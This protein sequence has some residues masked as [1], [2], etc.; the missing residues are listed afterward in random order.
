MRKSCTIEIDHAKLE[1]GKVLFLLTD[2][3]HDISCHLH[4]TYFYKLYVLL[5]KT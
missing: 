3:N 1:T 5:N 4:L 2:Y